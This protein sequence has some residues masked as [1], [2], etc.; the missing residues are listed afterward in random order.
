MAQLVSI[1]VAQPK[2]W[3]SPDAIEPDDKLWTTAFYKLPVTGPV[4][5]HPLGVFGDSQADQ[6]NHGG[7]DKAVCAYSADHY[8]AWQT[9]LQLPDFPWGAFGENFTLRGLT[10][11][12]VCVGDIFE[13]AQGP[14]VQISQPRQPCWKLARRWRMKNLALQVQENGKTGW[15]FRVLRPG[16]IAAGD[17]LRLV[18]RPHA[19]WTVARANQIMHHDQRNLDAAQALAEVPALSLSWKNSLL[20]RVRKG[21]P[22]PSA[23]RLTGGATSP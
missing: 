20:D 16:T 12:D 14:V 9:E 5:L 21:R 23:Q 22:S 15:Y 17:S 10:E 6:A 3:G 19:D 1:Q 18:E 13:L 2:S 4:E 8:P 11:P 7:P